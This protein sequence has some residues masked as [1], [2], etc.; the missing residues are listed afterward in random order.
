MM[1]P[2]AQLT[3]SQ[4]VAKVMWVWLIKI[5]GMAAARLRFGLIGCGTIVNCHLRGLQ[6]A[7][8]TCLITALVDID[9]EAAEKTRK[10]IENGESCQVSLKSVTI[11]LQSCSVLLL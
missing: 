1:S 10:N 4:H 6:A 11:A 3:S 2:P 7:T 5:A 8:P 9:R